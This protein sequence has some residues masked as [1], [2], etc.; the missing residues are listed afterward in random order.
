LIINRYIHLNPVRVRALGATRLD[1]A[2]E[3]HLRTGPSRELVKARVEALSSYRWSSYPTYVGR[4]RKP[5]WLTT[6]SIY[7]FFGRH[8][9]HSLR[10]AYRRQLEKMAAL[11][12]LETDWRASIKATV[13]LGS[14]KFIQK[15]LGFLKGDRRELTGLRSKERLSLDWPKITNAISEIWGTTGRL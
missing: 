10:G 11:G 1:Q 15:I 4:V 5:G 14:D 12:R 6:E 9:L 2:R 7:R 13:L 3:A 8:T